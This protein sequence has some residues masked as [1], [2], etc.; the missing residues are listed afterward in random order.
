M[1]KKIEIA[2]N[3]MK[4]LQADLQTNNRKILEFNE[5]DNMT[6][7]LLAYDLIFENQFIIKELQEIENKITLMEA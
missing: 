3:R 6:L 7:E 5:S 4:F 1:D 2:V